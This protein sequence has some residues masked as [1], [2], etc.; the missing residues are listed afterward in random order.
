M[1]ERESRAQSALRLAKEEGAGGVPDV[2][3]V[4]TAEAESG[5]G[6]AAPG[7]ARSPAQTLCVST[8]LCARAGRP[9]GGS[10]LVLEVRVSTSPKGPFLLPVPAFTR[11]GS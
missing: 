10:R 8:R 6:A 3:Q 2:S 4:L 1:R 9:P 7:L 5:P 11:G